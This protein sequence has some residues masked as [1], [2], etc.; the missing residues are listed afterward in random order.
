M[1][2]L[3]I[4]DIIIPYEI[5]VN[6]RA[7]RLAIR[8][9]QGNVKISVPRNIPI[10]QAQTFIEAKK[11][12]I[13]KHWQAQNAERD[14]GRGL[15]EGSEIPYLG[16]NLV[17]HIKI[18]EGRRLK[19]SRLNNELTIFLPEGLPQE[20]QALLLPEGLKQW[21]KEEARR[22]LW[23]KLDYY[24]QALGVEYRQF[25]LKEQKT[26]WGSCSAEGNINLNW[27]VI[28]AP[29]QVVDYLVIHE[30]AHLRHLNHSRDFW[31]L[32]E[33]HMP[34]YKRWRKWLRMHG[35]ELYL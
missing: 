30:L 13:L 35:K 3:I 24:A 17:L 26:R 21:Y 8:I 22:I 1:G 7:K 31:R 23:D 19:I 5:Q 6:S 18:Y 20:S 12:W 32:V 10:K 15:V 9:S 33:C 28:L 2:Q 25:R 14:G 29:E 11:E 34:E 27:R 4:N 16:N